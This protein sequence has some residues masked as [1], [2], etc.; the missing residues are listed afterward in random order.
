VEQDYR[1]MLSVGMITYNHEPYIAKAIEGVLMQKTNFNYEFVIGEDCSIDNTAKIIIEYARKRPDI[2]VPLY[3]DIN[4]GMIPNFIRTLEKCNG[5]YFTFCEGD[6]Y[7]TDPYKLQKQVDFLE[8]NKEYGLCYGDIIIVKDDDSLLSHDPSWKFFY[9]SGYVFSDLFVQNFIPTLTVAVRKELL[10]SAC[11][12]LKSFPNLKLF[13][14]WFWLYISMFTKFKYLDEKL[15]AYRDHSEGIT[16]SKEFSKENF[17]L[18]VN[19]IKI[20]I[21]EIYCKITRSKKIVPDLK[22]KISLMKEVLQLFY[23]APNSFIA[24]WIKLK[25]LFKILIS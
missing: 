16:D 3:S 24:G 9:K 21:I 1:L 6:D 22:E 17:L 13:D 12:T 15:A 18:M 20:N 11:Q 5:K 2:I 10:E 14:Y 4:R 23:E 25:Y 8:K 7:W 19:H